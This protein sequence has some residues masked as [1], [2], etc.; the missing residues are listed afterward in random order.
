MRWKNSG[1]IRSFFILSYN[2]IV[3]IIARM[4]KLKEAKILYDSIK[5][6]AVG[7]CRE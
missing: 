7:G 2:G 6:E 3:Q 1:A 4:A 5:I